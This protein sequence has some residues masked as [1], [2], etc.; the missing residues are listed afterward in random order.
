M[1]SDLPIL[2]ER[3][4][5]L[6]G[7]QEFDLVRA[8]LDDAGPRLS[9]DTL[10]LCELR[11]RNVCEKYRE[12][13]KRSRR[14]RAAASDPESMEKIAAR[15]TVLEKARDACRERICQSGAAEDRT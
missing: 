2:L 13:F 4:R 10:S 14:V 12:Q 3:A 6:L 11:L 5:T 8:V 15:L 7:R 1:T 9:L